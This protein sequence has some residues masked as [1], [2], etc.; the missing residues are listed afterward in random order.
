MNWHSCCYIYTRPLAI[1]PVAPWSE[2]MATATYTKLKD[3]TWGVRVNGT[4]AAG[5][6]ITVSKRDGSS[7]TETVAKVLWTGI[8]R[9]GQQACLVEIGRSERSSA[10]RSNRGVWTGCSC[11]S[12]ELPEGGL[13]DNA[14]A[15]CRFDE[16][17]C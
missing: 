8:A 5:E 17:D 14:C 10:R 7:K 15:T 4:V 3:G 1:T 2:K 6:R 13:S 16:Y 12:R 11:G 9:D